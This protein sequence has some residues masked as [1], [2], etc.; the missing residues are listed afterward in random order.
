MYI[1]L[2]AMVTIHAKHCN[3]TETIAKGIDGHN[4]TYSRPQTIRRCLL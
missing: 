1:H 2:L 4:D 3:I